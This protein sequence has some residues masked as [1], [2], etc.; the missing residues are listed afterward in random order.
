MIGSLPPQ[1]GVSQYT[2]DLAYEVARRD[3]VEL[4]IVSFR[5]L[6]PRRFYP[7]GNPEDGSARALDVPGAPTRRPLRWWNPIGWLLA[8][9]TLRGDVVHAQWWTFVLAPV[10][11]TL[12][13]IA[14]L[15]GK[16]VVVTVH[17]AQPHEGGLLRR[18]ANR[19]V[20]PFADRIVVHTQVN[21]A[22]LVASGVA[23]ERISIVPIGVGAPCAVDAPAVAAARE[24]LGIDDTAPVALFHGNIRPYKGL[25]DLLASFRL[26]AKTMPSARLV[27]AGQP[28]GPADDILNEIQSLGLDDNVIA[29]LEYLPSETLDDLFIAADV[30]VYPYTHFDAQSAAACDA[31]RYGKAIIVTSVGGLPDLV[32]NSAAIVPPRRPDTLA[33]AII[34]VL[35]DRA[36]RASLEEDARAIAAELAWPRIAEMTESVYRATSD[37]RFTNGH[38]AQQTREEVGAAKEAT[39]R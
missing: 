22:S 8:G 5:S 18:L 27:V 3:G 1:R 11:V 31:I 36:L 25:S 21:A 16:R 30:V 32:R 2:H 33:N 29:R 15:R 4:D 28:W 12:L 9:L 6:Y 34:G 24:R 20:I 35:R 26:V 14:R 23:P 19:A 7:G 37:A 17:N 13:A 38:T 10:Y 39:W